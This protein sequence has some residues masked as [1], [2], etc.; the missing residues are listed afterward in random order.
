MRGHDQLIALRRERQAPQIVFVNDYPCDT[1]WHSVG[2][3]VTLCVAGDS[4][5]L[6]DLR[7]LVG[8][9]VSISSPDEAR[10]KALAERCKA[11]GAATVAACH[12]LSGQSP[13]D[14]TGWAEVW[15]RTEQQKQQ[16]AA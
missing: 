5:P 13:F 1:D 16:E 3:H 12:V 6:L 11:S 15:H 4:V 8:L 9:R 2:A 14:Q 10:A 7:C